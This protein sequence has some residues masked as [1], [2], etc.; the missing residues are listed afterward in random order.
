MLAWSPRKGDDPAAVGPGAQAAREAA[1]DEHRRLLYV[2]MTRAEERLYI[3]GFYNKTEPN[4][5][6]WS[7]MIAAV[8]DDKFVEVPAD[9]N[10]DETIWRYAAPGTV[11]HIVE[12]A[13]PAAAAEIALPAWLSQPAPREAAPLPPL[14][15]SNALAAG[16]PEV[17]PP[18]PQRRVAL[19]RGRLVHTLLQYLPE[20][21]AAQRHAAAEAFLNL[22]A[23]DYADAREL[24][25]TVLGVIEAPALAA[26]F[27]PRARA[28]V[29]VAGTVT[30]PNGAARDVLGQIDR[31]AE[32]EDEVILAD[33][34][35][36]APVAAAATP[37]SYLAQM[38]LYRA[39]LASLW[40]GKSLRCL[41]IWTAGPEIV[42]LSAVQLDA[43]LARLA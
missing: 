27:G 25:A 38:A 41:L 15:P 13:A 16:E 10:R 29:A 12:E 43:A 36:G 21:E 34:K 39:L 6:A 23:P 2:A 30:L 32:S 3:S 24:I 14:R 5:R 1:E 9:W 40:P 33:Y 19:Q 42:D 22:R 26:L 17:P 11:E 31:I 7:R 35:T 18:N 20:V 28:E 37:E 4:E 8:Q